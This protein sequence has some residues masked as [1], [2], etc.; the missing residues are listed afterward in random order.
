MSG[1][2][3]SSV[4][5]ETRTFRAGPPFAERLFPSRKRSEKTLWT[6]PRSELKVMVSRRT[7]VSDGV[8]GSSQVEQRAEHEP[9]VG[10]WHD[11][12]CA[13][14]PSDLGGGLRSEDEPLGQADVGA[15]LLHTSCHRRDS[16]RRAIPSRDRPHRSRRSSRSLN[17]LLVHRHSHW[18][19]SRG[20]C[21]EVTMTIPEHRQTRR[22][23][24]TRLAQLSFQLALVC[25]TDFAQIFLVGEDESPTKPAA[26]RQDSR[27]PL[28]IMLLSR[29]PRRPD[30]HWEE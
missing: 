3:R 8:S 17:E 15:V 25:A 5:S 21:G 22:S 7:Q 19:R 12:H 24:S 18:E 30:G 16:R 27:G 9:K 23:P 4:Q 13:R 6:A 10:A 26:A 2:L 29:H 11:H 20:M 1:G 28:G 14:I